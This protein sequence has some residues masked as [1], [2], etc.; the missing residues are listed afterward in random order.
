MVF[1]IFRYYVKRVYKCIAY[2]YAMKIYSIR[3]GVIEDG[4]KQ[5]MSQEAYIAKDIFRDK[6][7]KSFEMEERYE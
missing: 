7:F 2:K 3:I 6:K 1:D 4:G 5:C